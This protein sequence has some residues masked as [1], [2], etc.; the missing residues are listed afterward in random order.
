MYPCFL[1][2]SLG[3]M[4]AELNVGDTPINTRGYESLLGVVNT[5]CK[6]SFDLFYGL[7]KYNPNARTEL[8][9]LEEALRNIRFKLEEAERSELETKK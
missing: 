4:L 9:N 7:Y 2:C 8:D 6:D 5:T 1:R 3:R